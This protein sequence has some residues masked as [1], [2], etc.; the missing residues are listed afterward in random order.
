M[1]R[2]AAPHLQ[3]RMLGLLAVLALVATLLLGRLGQLQLTDDP[4][5]GGAAQAPPGTARV[6]VPAL[7]GRI[8]D[9]D[10]VPIVDHEVRTDVTV[11]RRVLADAED[12]G[13]ALVRRLAR[14]L[15]RP[16]DRLWGRTT[17]CGAPG[18][19]PRPLCWPGSAY[20]P[21]PIA[22]GVDPA[23]AVTLTEEAEH[24]P[25]VSVTTRPVRAYPQVAK[26][27]AAP[28]TVG[29]LARPSTETVAGSEGRIGD[30]DLVG[31]A[32]LER[33]Y[34][35]RL[36][37]RPGERVV[38]V[39]ARGVPV[40]EVSATE[41]VPGDDLVTTLDVGVQRASERALAD[42]IAEARRRGRPAT[43]G[44]AVVLDLRDGGVVASASAPT[45]DPSVWSRGVSTREYRR[46]TTGDA[47]PL[48]DRVTGV[49]QPPASTF[50]AVTLPGAVAAG[51][52]LE[53][54]VACTASHRIG[55]RVF[56]N[57]ESRAYG[58][59]SWR[60]AMV[61]SCDTVFYRVAERVW[62]EHGGLD[63]DQ[64]EG[65][66]LIGVARDLGLGEPTGIDLPA[67]SSGRIPGRTW[68]RDYWEAT[69][70]DTCRR[71]RDGYPEMRDRSRAAY[72]QALAKESCAT[73]YQFRPGDEANLSIGQ[74][75]VTATLLQ[76][77]RVYG[78]VALDGRDPQP[79]LASAFVRPDGSREEVATPAARRVSLPG[80]SGELLRDSL[81]GV[82]TTG[83][84]APA[85]RGAQLPGWPVAGKTG[86][87]EVYGEEDTSWF[88]SWA[89]ST[90]PRYVVGVVV[91]EGGTGGSTAAGVARAIHEHLA[92]QE[93]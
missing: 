56:R 12:G 16:F 88:V 87:A 13:R 61:V 11:D 84:A 72:L 63:A 58:T 80:D 24:Y 1:A 91:D 21:V 10:G 65:D 4:P 83:T 85:F 22:E 36:R 90:R 73:G 25:G 6:A 31:A 26:G 32:G 62:E 60:T 51:T 5:V 66:P 92:A 48:I 45:Y 8:L 43:A 55:D 17:L 71:A 54:P 15:D 89:P 79:H 68:K 75:D 18:A 77:A 20:V 3:V 86:T 19:S 29:Y 52:D 67:E 57:F 69:K 44:G 9:R 30:D 40:E 41:P 27:G 78:A 49:A 70:D 14:A 74:G 42:G 2:R 81:R 82:V 23:L 64:D 46:L 76:M 33:Q 7:R 47:S 93:R 34:D 28:Q 50:K 38:R 39:D 53:Q 35:E 59:I 37:G